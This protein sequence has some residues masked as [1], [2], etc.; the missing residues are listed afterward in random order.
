MLEVLTQSQ[1]CFLFSDLGVLKTNYY[2]VRL[3]FYYLEAPTYD[4]DSVSWDRYLQR[5]HV[6]KS[7]KNIGDQVLNLK[8]RKI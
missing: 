5:C 4:N 2:F 3:F 7:Y 8:E 1:F 6:Q